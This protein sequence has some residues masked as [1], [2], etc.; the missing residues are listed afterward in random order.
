MLVKIEKDITF[1]T[2]DKHYK[3]LYRFIEIEGEVDLL[4][5]K[6]LDNDFMGLVP[7][8]IQFV[9]TWIRYPHRGKLLLN[10]SDPANEK[11]DEL[12]QKEHLYPIVTLALND[13]GIYNS[14]GQTNLL[15]YIKPSID[16]MRDIMV[17]IKP[18][19]GWKLLLTS[20]DHFP[21]EDGLLPCF[22]EPTGYINNENTISRNLKPAIERVL[23]LSHEALTGYLAVEIHF[24]AIIHEL[25]KNTFEWGKTDHFNVPLDPSIR[26][27]LFK[28]RRRK[29]LTFIKEF[30]M[31]KGLVS[32]FNQPRLQEN[33]QGEL[34]ILEI[35]VYDSG[36]GFVN[37]YDGKEKDSLSEVEI[38]KSCLIKH[39][40][41]ARGLEK[42]E[43]GIGLDRILHL[44]DNRGFLRIKTNKSCVYR[45]LITHPYRTVNKEK[46]MELFDWGSQSSIEYTSFPNA[47]GSTLTIL[48]PLVIN[49]YL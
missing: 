47:E 2:I 38:I 44:L 16:M 20:V 23:G 4:I 9:I 25:M 45:N 5:P 31:H 26:G 41:S 12:F 30:G 35:S 22:E 7:A 39:N 48:Y 36:I 19:K 29:R 18:L 11:W 42:D 13:T 46:D 37:K 40:T 17:K 1:D 6:I 32:Y 27:V 8:L 14:T 49:P 24:V 28:F 10:V 43:K 21:I 33:T 34:Y 3:L 15:P